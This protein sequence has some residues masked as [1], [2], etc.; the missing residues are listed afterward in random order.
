M[1]ETRVGKDNGMNETEE[2]N[3]PQKTPSHSKPNIISWLWHF[4]DVL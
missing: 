4:T 2:F 1:K 3:R